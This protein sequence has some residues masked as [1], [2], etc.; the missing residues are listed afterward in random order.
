ME[1]CTGLL[2]AASPTARTPLLLRVEDSPNAAAHAAHGELVAP[3]PL[4]TSGSSSSLSVS[5]GGTACTYRIAVEHIPHLDPF[6]PPNWRNTAHLLP[7]LPVSHT[8][9]DRSDVDAGA[10]EVTRGDLRKRMQR[11]VYRTRVQEHFYGNALLTTGSDEW[12]RALARGRYQL[13]R[14]QELSHVRK[15]RALRKRYNWESQLSTE[16]LIFLL[17]DTERVSAVQQGLCNKD[18]YGYDP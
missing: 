10:L 14:V 11:A 5:R 12:R 17:K 16:E 7:S 6:M 4:H 8:P 3:A 1:E 2:P 15:F 13:R 9:L 18:T